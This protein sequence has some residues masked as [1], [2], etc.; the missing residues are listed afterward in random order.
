[1]L[2]YASEGFYLRYI[3]RTF[4]GRNL[5]ISL[6]GFLKNVSDISTL[7][8]TILVLYLLAYKQCNS[9]PIFFFHHKPYFYLQ[10]YWFIVLFLFQSQDPFLLWLPNSN[11]ILSLFF[12]YNYFRVLFLGSQSNMDRKKAHKIKCLAYG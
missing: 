10:T 2:G 12:W 6:L 11:I 1:M 3:F 9:I 4:P 7:F 8:F 5:Y